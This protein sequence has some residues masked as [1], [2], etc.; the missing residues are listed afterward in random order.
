MIDKRFTFTWPPFLCLFMGI[1]GALC[2]RFALHLPNDY[3]VWCDQH[4]EI[5]RAFAAEGIDGLI[6]FTV[7]VAWLTTVMLVAT[8]L[9]C[10]SRRSVTTL[11]IFRK[12]CLLSYA[13]A[14]TF[15]AVMLR[16]TQI[17]V[18][19]ELSVDGLEPTS[20]NIFLL[21]WDLFLPVIGASIAMAVLYVLAWRRVAI[22]AWT[23]EP[24][25]T[26]ATGDLFLE[27][28]RTHGR[29][30]RF[31]KSVWSSFSLHLLIILILPWLLTSRGGCV[32]NYLVPKGSG[33][34]EV[35]MPK[36]VKVVKKKKKKR[37]VVNPQ[38]AISFHIP[39]LD[40]SP[41][42]QEVD[43]ES[44][45]TYVADPTRVIAGKGGKMGAGGGKEGGWP[46][47]MENSLV[48]FI[49]LKYN[50]SGWDDGMDEVARADIN[51]LASF[52]K[53]TGFRTAPQ[54]ES[55][56]I[57]AL[58]KYPKGFAP[59]FVFMTGHA[60]IRISDSEVRILREYLMG[61]GMLF[62]DCSSARWNTSFRTFMLR[63][64]PG[65]PLLTISDDD[66]IFQLPYTFPNGAP[67]LWHHGGMRALGI[68]YKGRWAVFY[69]PGDIHDAWKSDRGG[70]TPQMA[71]GAI[72]MGVNIVYY[73]F[74][75][76]LELTRK[77][78]K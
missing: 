25:E 29:D 62:A 74:S 3:L 56:T 70:L 38:S 44:R 40:E 24:D 46:D 60:D 42:A 11:G 15:G 18:V 72:E 1:A 7:G 23:G 49:R 32:N 14:W 16:A 45:V 53:M 55:H 57:S 73:S 4:P 69:H 50:G 47:G 68:K 39:E 5:A 17:L 9:V 12:V 37:V 63:V 65:E 58:A 77:Y 21:R 2:M 41:V 43:Q 66:V 13:T 35:S 28:I 22:R 31:R 76:Y 64:F 6:R 52:R 71:D 19:R 20:Y 54:S 10:L 36:I 67:P 61:G 26:P 59:P 51:F 34:P 8:A 75:N 33:T 30:P 78:R 48:R 27:N